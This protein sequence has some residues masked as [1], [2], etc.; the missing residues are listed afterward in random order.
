MKDTTINAAVRK[1][2]NLLRETEEVELV[3]ASKDFNPQAARKIGF[4]AVNQ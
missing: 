4:K 3:A 1:L 2:K